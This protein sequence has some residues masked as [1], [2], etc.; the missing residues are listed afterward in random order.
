MDLILFP[1]V[2]IPRQL[3]HPNIVQFHG[4]AKVGDDFVI[5]MSY[6]DGSNLDNMIFGKNKVEVKQE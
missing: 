1:T 4:C 3:N 6:V 5:V 2:N